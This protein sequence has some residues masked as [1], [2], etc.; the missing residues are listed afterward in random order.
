MI[1]TRGFRRKFKNRIFPGNRDWSELRISPT[2]LVDGGLKL[3]N[4]LSANK[5]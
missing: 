3:V 5:R 4:L 1:V 2:G